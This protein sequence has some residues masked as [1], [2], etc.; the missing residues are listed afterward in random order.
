MR[1]ISGIHKGRSI[2]AVPGKSTRPTTDKVKESIFNLIG[3]P[4]FEG[5][6][7]L[8]L[9]AGTGGLGIEALSRGLDKMIFVDQNRKAFDII[10]QNLE[11][12]DLLDR[13]EVYKNDADR[14]LKAIIKREL[15]FDLIF[16]DPPYAEQKIGAQLGLIQQYQLLKHNGTVVVETG[17]SITLPEKVGEI[18]LVKH[19][20][21]GETEIRIYVHKGREEHGN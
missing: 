17:N 20:Q 7:G 8:D 10:K 16:L 6:I 2:H 11:A 3:Q 4:Y 5:G 12:L 9:Y 18:E 13:S 1:V 19:H 15:S 21:Y 14:A